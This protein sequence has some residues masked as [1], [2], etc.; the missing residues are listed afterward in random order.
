MKVELLDLL[1]TIRL[2]IEM[3]FG[4]WIR[5]GPRKQTLDSGS[6]PACDF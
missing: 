3:Q 4:P 1:R 2:Q 5:M 6:D